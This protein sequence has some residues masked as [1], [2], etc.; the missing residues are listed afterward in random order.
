[1]SSF[2]ILILSGYELININ[3]K[4]ADRSLCFLCYEHVFIKGKNAFWMD[5]RSVFC[6]LFLICFIPAA[7]AAAKSL[8]PYSISIQSPFIL[9]YTLG[10]NL[11]RSITKIPSLV[12]FK[13][14]S[15]N[16]KHFLRYQKQKE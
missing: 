8:H 12:G 2:T 11:H 1:M 10:A 15:G 16:E 7:A 9:F 14:D 6:L 3:D 13:L 4:A 5:K